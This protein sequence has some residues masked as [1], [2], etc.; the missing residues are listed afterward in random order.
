[1]NLEPIIF[2]ANDNWFQRSRCGSRG[3]WQA[4][5]LWIALDST[6]H[7][8]A[9]VQK[10]RCHGHAIAAFQAILYFVGAPKQN[11][12]WS[13]SKRLRSCANAIKDARLD[14]YPHFKK[15]QIDVST[16]VA[17]LSNCRKD[18]RFSPRELLPL[19]LL[20]PLLSMFSVCSRRRPAKPCGIGP[21]QQA[22]CSLPQHK[23]SWRRGFAMAPKPNV[24]VALNSGVWEAAH[25]HHAIAFTLTRQVTPGSIAAKMVKCVIWSNYVLTWGCCWPPGSAPEA[26]AS[27]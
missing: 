13:F 14:L 7:V 6:V 21:L 18:G 10:S 17:N 27:N 24:L 2:R 15:F 11:A 16:G 25:M 3:N 12:E 20:M 4:L 5:K 8:Q 9:P 1:M 23:W 26:P 19:P 22:S